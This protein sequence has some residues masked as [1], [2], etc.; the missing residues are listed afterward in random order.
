MSG[1]SR[2]KESVIGLVSKI[3]KIDADEQCSSA[4]RPEWD[5]LAQMK[6]VVELE[7]S[8]DLEIED[9]MLSKLNSVVA[10]V[11]YLEAKGR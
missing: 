1:S 10:I 3:L 5:S 4:K 6:I 8:F 2:L 7:K 11:S 9:E